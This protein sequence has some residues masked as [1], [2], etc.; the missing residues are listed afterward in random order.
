MS[1]A[2]KALQNSAFLT[3]TD[4]RGG[5]VQEDTQIRTLLPI[6]SELRG[7]RDSFSNQL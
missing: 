2:D 3:M 4:D 5:K 6:L 7:Q 1:K